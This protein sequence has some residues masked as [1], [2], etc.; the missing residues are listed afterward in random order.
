MQETIFRTSPNRFKTENTRV[1]IL[2][3]DA[4][5]FIT[6]IDTK[7]TWR[8][9]R[10]TWALDPW[11]P[12]TAGALGF[13]QH[14]LLHVHELSHWKRGAHG[15]IRHGSIQTSERTGPCA[16]SQRLGRP[17]SW[18]D[19]GGMHLSARLPVSHQ[20]LDAE[21]QNSNFGLP[22]LL[23]G[24]QACLHLA[25]AEHR[26]GGKIFSFQ[27]S[28]QSWHGDRWGHTGPAGTA[29]GALVGIV[30]RESQTKLQYALKWRYPHVYVTK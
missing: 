7:L 28:G 15:Q 22:G 20:R 11:R 30:E 9:W 6:L 8:S 3:V 2:Y 12:L 18:L 1:D 13:Y 4:I 16:L 29:E 27:T 19:I 26:A 23:C 25:S 17:G 5:Y 24:T 14:V 21:G 10:K